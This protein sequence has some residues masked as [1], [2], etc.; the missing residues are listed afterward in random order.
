MSRAPEV[1]GDEVQR[2]ALEASINDKVG[3]GMNRIHT[4]DVLCSAISEE[5]IPDNK[6]LFVTTIF[7]TGE[8]RPVK[9]ISLN[10]KTYSGPIS[11]STTGA[12]QGSK[13]R[14]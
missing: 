3:L 13:I 6:N 7:G 10:I 4:I 8:E 14:R 11:K 1:K 5:R 12:T 9:N 2:L